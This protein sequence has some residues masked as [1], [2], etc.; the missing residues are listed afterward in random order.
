MLRTAQSPAK[1]QNGPRSGA[2]PGTRAATARSVKADI[3]EAGIVRGAFVAYRVG[4]LR[5]RDTL[6]LRQVLET[7]VD[8]WLATFC[9]SQMAAWIPRYC[10]QV[11]WL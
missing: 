9:S 11:S 4:S 1:A 7:Q 5:A 2:H 3:A 10:L 6:S 8:D